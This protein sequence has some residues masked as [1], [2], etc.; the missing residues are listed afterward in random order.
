MRFEIRQDSPSA[1]TAYASV[2][3]AFE[4]R[5]RFAVRVPE[6]GR[7]GISLEAE[8]VEPS[9]I[10]DYDAMP[11]EGPLTWPSRFDL[12][13]WGFLSAWSGLERVGGA[14]IVKSAPDVDMLEGRSDLAL[15]WDIRVAPTWRGRGV[16]TELFQAAEAWARLRRA[17]WIKVETQNVNVP[18]CRFYLRQGCVLA[19][20]HP[21][22]YPVAPDEVQLLWYKRLGG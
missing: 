11:G 5:E 15:L 22:A 18:A 12:S 2:P 20:V 10:K 7:R 6:P 3:I 16:G 14:A 13:T 4:V 1:L 19:Q 17:S 9:Y 21:L 8:P